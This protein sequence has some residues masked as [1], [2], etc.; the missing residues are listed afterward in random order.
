MMEVCATQEVVMVSMVVIAAEQVSRETR[1]KL[2][3]TNV[4]EDHRAKIVERAPIHLVL[5]HA[6][7][8]R[9]SAEIIAKK[10]AME[11]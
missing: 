10:I 11:L 2:I 3:L 9:V 8:H 4:Y 6:L 5:I 1:A 7:V